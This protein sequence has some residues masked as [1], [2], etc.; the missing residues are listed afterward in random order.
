MPVDPFAALYALLRAEA[1]RQGRKP[2]AGEPRTEP[3]PAARPDAGQEQPEADA[4][5]PKG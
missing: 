2:R 5:S 1:A 4:D 3:G